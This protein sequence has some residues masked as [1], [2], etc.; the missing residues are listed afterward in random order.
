MDQVVQA[1]EIE[2]GIDIAGVQC[3]KAA[4][5]DF[6]LEI[7]VMW[8]RLA[9]STVSRHLLHPWFRLAR[10]L[11]LGVRVAVSDGDG[12]I[13]LVRHTYAPGWLFPGGGVE[14]GETALAAARREVAE[15]AGIIATGTLQ[16]FGLYAN[17]ANFPGDHIALYVLEHFEQQERRSSLEIAEA[18]FFARDALPEGVTGGTLRRLAEMAGERAVEEMW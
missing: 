5:I 13:L 6:V 12:R 10:G 11:T 4:V 8:K 3:G 7:R 15:E 16:L 14:R 2:A 17:E 9:F 18:G 1:P